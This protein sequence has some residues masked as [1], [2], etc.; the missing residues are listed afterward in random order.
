MQGVT[1]G[2]AMAGRAAGA[3]DFHA[4]ALTL[5]MADGRR[6]RATFAPSG[7]GTKVTAIFDAETQHSIAMQREGWQAILDNF[8]SHV[9]TQAARLPRAAPSGCVARATCVRMRSPERSRL[10]PAGPRAADQTLRP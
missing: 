3:G 7:D 8:V 2:L 4:R 10:G 5:A 1:A 9:G 6:A